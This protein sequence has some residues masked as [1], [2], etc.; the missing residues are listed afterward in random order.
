M[1]IEVKRTSYKSAA[2]VHFP[3]A[4]IN[5]EEYYAIDFSDLIDLE[6][7]VVTDISWET[8]PEII[9]SDSYINTEFNEA[10]VKLNPIKAGIYK[11][12]CVITSEDTGRIQ[13]PRKEV[14]L[15][16]G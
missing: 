8:P 2:G 10:H 7:E 5:T 12:T 15:R 3:D 1:P 4:V 9:A 16:V 14:I 6:S 13:R 11:I